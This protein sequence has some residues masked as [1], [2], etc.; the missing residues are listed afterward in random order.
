[1]EVKEL[2]DNQNLYIDSHQQ[3]DGQA[4]R[5]NFLHLH[6][7]MNGKKLKGWEIKIY[8]ESNEIRVDYKKGFDNDSLE[9]RNVKNEIQQIF[10]NSDDTKLKQLIKD[11]HEAIKSYYGNKLSDNEIKDK[12]MGWSKRIAEGFGLKSSI[13]EKI[14]NK[15]S[16][17]V[18]LITSHE[19]ASGKVYFLKQD[20]N[21]REIPIAMSDDM[22]ELYNRTKRR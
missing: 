2:L 22:N 10:K 8:L 15:S 16:E 6:K 7:K 5:E 1:M 18:S 3:G 17:Y 4:T 14:I 21:P 12:L 19:D 9:T 11:L 13:K 20:T